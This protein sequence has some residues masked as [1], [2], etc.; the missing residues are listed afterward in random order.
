MGPGPDSYKVP[1]SEGTDVGILK[2][3]EDLPI[4]VMTV[5]AKI[6]ALGQFQLLK[7]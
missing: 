5:A 7:V 2:V 1:W 4:V 3:P 6:I